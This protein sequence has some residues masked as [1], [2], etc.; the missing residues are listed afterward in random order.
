[1]ASVLQA[2]PMV[3][4]ILVRRG[5]PLPGCDALETTPCVLGFLFKMSPGQSTRGIQCNCIK[6]LPIAARAPSFYLA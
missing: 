2:G 5:E 3:Q 1:M 4:I 6:I